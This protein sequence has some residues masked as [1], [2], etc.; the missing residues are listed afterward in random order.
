MGICSTSA[1]WHP[2]R[3]FTPGS[4]F[5]KSLDGRKRRRD[6]LRLAEPG[7]LLAVGP[8]DLNLPLVPLL[9]LLF[10]TT[11]S[12]WYI[13]L[14][15]VTERCA[16]ELPRIADV[17]ERERQRKE[18]WAGIHELNR[19]GL[20]LL[21]SRTHDGRSLVLSSLSDSILTCSDCV[22]FFYGELSALVYLGFMFYVGRRFAHE[23]WTT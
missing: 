2:V 16:L 8:C 5:I 7:G 12:C 1:A 6:L 23:S 10:V 21:I 9:R 14:A 19:Y 3:T 17:E 20:S 11:I 22:L 13:F 15:C 4:C 18:L